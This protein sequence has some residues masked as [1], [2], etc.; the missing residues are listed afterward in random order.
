MRKAIRLTGRKQLAQAAFDFRF[1]RLNGRSVATLA[2]ASPAALRSFPATAEIRVKLTEN[3]LVR[4][5][6]FGTV[7]RPE[8]IAD[9][10]SDVFRAPSCQ[11]RVVNRGQDRDGMLLGS[12]REWTLT[13]G[14]EPDGILLFQAAPIAP[15]L[16]SLDIRD[17]EP[18][19]VY[20]DESIPDAGLWARTDPIF[21]ACVAPAIVTEIL[22]AILEGREL[23][24]GGWE[25]DWMA[26]AFELLPNTKPPFNESYEKKT[27][28]IGELL[29]AFAA[30]H[31]FVG[32]VLPILARQDSAS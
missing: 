22:R 16:W 31:N 25:A 10:D 30:R 12:T 26:W 11:V 27:E 32:S 21:G 19:I 9:I 1:S 20:I 14:G 15:R 7:A 18:P 2:I 23:P 29:D 24:E 6:T 17:Q 5:L 13:S 4:V 8:P 28:W 3:K